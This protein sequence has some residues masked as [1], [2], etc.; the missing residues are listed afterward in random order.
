M[1]N[2]FI[3]EDNYNTGSI[4]RK[5]VSEYALKI[6]LDCTIHLICSDFD[7]VIEHAKSNIGHANIFF[8]DMILN[9]ENTT[10]LTLAREI[11]KIDVM[12]YLIFITSHP[13]LSLKVF[14]YK[15]KALDYIYKHDED[16]QKRICE[17]IDS[18]IAEVKK[19]GFLDISKQVIL[20]SLNEVYTIT[21][22]DIVYFETIP[23]SRLLN[24]VLNDGTSIE[25]YD[26]LKN[27]MKK[28]DGRFC[29]CHRSF[30]I[31]FQH[32]RRLG[33]GKPLYTVTMSTGKVCDVSKTKWKDLVER[34]RA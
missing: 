23:N 4:I 27:V 28:L 34:V 19:I 17:C 22:A 7:Q 26:T 14:Q 30:I 13:E 6:N 16:I 33:G 32:V 18:I 25:F 29:H 24:C 12:A 31:N 21:P 5:F 1:Y 11:R 3:C 10:G 15:L 20:K 9:Q 2:F 8:L